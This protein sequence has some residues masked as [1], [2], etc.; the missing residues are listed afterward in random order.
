MSPFHH[1]DV[2]MRQ[3]SACFFWKPVMMVSIRPVNLMRPGNKR[4][5]LSLRG[6]LWNSDWSLILLT[7]FFCPERENRT[8]RSTTHTNIFIRLN[9]EVLCILSLEM[10][11]PQYYSEIIISTFPAWCSTSSEIASTAK[12]K[13]WFQ[14]PSG[15]WCREEFEWILSV[16]R[17]EMQEMI[18]A[19]NRPGNLNVVESDNVGCFLGVSLYFHV[20]KSH[21]VTAVSSSSGNRP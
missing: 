20:V 17:Q 8:H 14:I 12:C 10:S 18:V 19:Q 5:L 15:S 4:D 16:R 7:H 11:G 3:F 2:M 1:T 9:L 13:M 6:P 21:E